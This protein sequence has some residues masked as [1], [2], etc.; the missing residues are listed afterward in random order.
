MEN[1]E[2]MQKALLDMGIMETAV[3]LHRVFTNDFLK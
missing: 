3:D 1:W 2:A